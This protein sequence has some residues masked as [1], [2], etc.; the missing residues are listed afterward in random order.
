MI[1]KTSKAIMHRAKHVAAAMP[2]W[3]MRFLQPLAEELQALRRAKRPAQDGRLKN[4]LAAITAL[5]DAR[6]I[7][8]IPGHGT[9]LSKAQFKAIVLSAG[10]REWGKTVQFAIHPAA[11]RLPGQMLAL[12]GQTDGLL[13]T[14]QSMDDALARTDVALIIGACDIVNPALAQVEGAHQRT[15]RVLAAEC[16]PAIVVCNQDR[17][18]GPSGIENPLYDNP[19]TTFLG[20]D[21]WQTLAV[22]IDNLGAP[23]DDSSGQA[24]LAN[25]ADAFK[26]APRVLGH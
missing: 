19:R 1:L 14:L 7:T 2:Q 17:T 16:A 6:H 13:T 24:I 9:A 4:L 21:A 22:L 23:D 12:L 11:G 26:T 25:G 10:L 5:R 15:Y 18:P 8:I 20:G 3:F